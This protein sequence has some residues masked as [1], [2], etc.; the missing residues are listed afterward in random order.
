RHARR[1][2]GCGGRSGSPTSR[3]HAGAF[4]TRKPRSP[5]R[6]EEAL[7]RFERS[8][9][10]VSEGLLESAIGAQGHERWARAELLR[11]A[12]RLREA[13]GWYR[14]LADVGIHGQPY[15]A[16][17]ELRQGQIEDRLGDRA[18]AVAHYRRAR[19]IWRDADPALAAMLR[20][21]GPPPP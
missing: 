20:A 12:G 16:P 2:F 8:R 13:L 17:A 18:R 1:S 5:R 9:I 14:S 3:W 21:A 11:E 19:E 10:V 6:R 15:L 7:A 4:A